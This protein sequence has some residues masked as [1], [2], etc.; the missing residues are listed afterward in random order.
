MWEAADPNAA[1]VTLLQEH[2]EYVEETEGNRVNDYSANE[3]R[4]EPE[5]ELKWLSDYLVQALIFFKGDL[6]IEDNELNAELIQ[7]MWGTLDFTSFQDKIEGGGAAVHR[8]FT[9]LRNAM[10]DLYAQKRVNKKTATAIMDYAKRTL[11]SHLQLYLTCLGNKQARRDKPI[12]IPV[13]V[14]QRAAGLDADCIEVTEDLDNPDA[15]Q[16]LDVDQSQ[17]NAMEGADLGE[18]SAQAS[19]QKEREPSAA[20]I[21]EFDTD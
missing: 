14:P 20:E 15:L 19:V 21:E 13:E 8:R 4:Y 11:F 1:I 16:V 17:G 5:S 12:S 7:M 10:A 6:S 9:F 2:L 3:K 18:G